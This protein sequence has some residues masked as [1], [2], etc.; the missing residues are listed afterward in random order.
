[1][2]FQK[3]NFSLSLVIVSFIFYFLSF[4]TLLDNKSK[5]EVSSILQVCLGLAS[6]I[7]SAIF[8]FKEEVDSKRIL[9]SL[10]FLTASLIC[11][12]IVNSTEWTF[13]RVGNIVVFLIPL[14]LFAI[15]FTNKKIEQFVG[16]SFI[17]MCIYCTYLAFAASNL[18]YAGAAALYIAFSI[19]LFNNKEE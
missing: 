13:L 7:I 10:S 15:S 14:I 2:N 12:N 3:K 6:T 1:M 19:K 16:I 8:Y 4:C 5:V 9:I 11:G 17:A 18:I